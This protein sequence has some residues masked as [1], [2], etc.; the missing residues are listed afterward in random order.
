MEDLRRP[1]R[2]PASFGFVLPSQALVG[3]LKDKESTPGSVHWRLLNTWV[4]IAHQVDSQEA[5]NTSYLDGG[6][7]SKRRRRWSAK[8]I[9]TT[10]DFAGLILR[11]GIK[12][13]L[14]ERARSIKSSKGDLCR[15]IRKGI[16]KVS[17]MM[18]LIII[19]M[20]K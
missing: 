4:R 17:V 6:F 10:T 9:N 12:L 8:E 3:I 16:A 5:R 1:G 19:R 7:C 15:V 13:A 14:K 18:L 11:R 2:A 20:A